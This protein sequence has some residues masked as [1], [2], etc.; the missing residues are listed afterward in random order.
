MTEDGGR[1]T[2]GRTTKDERQIS[3]P[4]S[5]ILQTLGQRGPLTLDQLAR[6]VRRSSLATRYHLGVL[7]AEGIVAP[8]QVA[9]RA[10][11]GRPQTLYALTPR[12]HA[13][14]PQQYDWLAQ[15]LLDELA[16]A[17][18]E[19]EL[20]A[21]LRRIGRRLAETAS[22]P[23]PTARLHTRIMRAVNFLCA[24]GYAARAEHANNGW[25]IAVHHCPYQHVARAERAVCEL[26]LALLD[27][28]VQVPFKMTRCIVRQDAECVFVLQT[29]ATKK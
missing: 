22:P 28:L 29:R 19:R 4:R 24:R 10:R 18:G 15:Q 20:R 7:M 3:H 25:M 6:A 26:D 12:A 5:I 11:V 2:E 17:C 21:A 14:L 1:K 8:S 16:R 9:H 27:A 13:Y 23:Y